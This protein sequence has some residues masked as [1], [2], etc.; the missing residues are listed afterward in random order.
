MSARLST[1]WLFLF[2]NQLNTAPSYG[3]NL[4]VR[5]FVTELAELDL[6]IKD[7]ATAALAPRQIT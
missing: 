2:A 6:F 1:P 5:F 7:F 4:A 3:T